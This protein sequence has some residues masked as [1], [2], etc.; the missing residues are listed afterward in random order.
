MSA[1]SMSLRCGARPSARLFQYRWSASILPLEPSS[2]ACRKAWPDF[3]A[4]SSG[5]RVRAI[6]VSS[7]RIAVDHDRC[8]AR[9]LGDRTCTR[10]RELKRRAVWVAVPCPETSAM[11]LDN[12][13]ADRKTHPHPVGLVVKNGSKIRS[14]MAGSMPAP[15]SST[16]T[17]RLS[18]SNGSEDI[19]S[20]R[21]RSAT[22]LMASMPFMIRFK[23]TCCN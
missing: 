2:L 11:N 21:G 22:A 8:S 15:V 4:L 18:S 23:T 13:P 9:F 7:R 17:T 1:G 16:V 5:I 19:S 14:T 6:R 12:R 10:H 3:P 20:T